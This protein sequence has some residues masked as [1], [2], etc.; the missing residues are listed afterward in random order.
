MEIEKIVVSV[1]SHHER[2]ENLKVQAHTMKDAY[3]KRN[4]W[5]SKRGAGEK[6]HVEMETYPINDAK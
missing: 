2:V 6:D 3:E 1:P 4:N 5:R